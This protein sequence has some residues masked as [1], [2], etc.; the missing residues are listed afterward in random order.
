MADSQEPVKSQSMAGSAKPAG[1]SRDGVRAV[2]VSYVAYCAVYFAR[3]PFSVVKKDAGENLALGT[4]E[5]AGVDTAFLVAYAVGQFALVSALARLGLAGISE[6]ESICVPK[7]DDRRAVVF[8]IY[9][10]LC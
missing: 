7:F 2:V 10:I 5:L 3:K 4:S 9:P 6:L 8:T 1:L